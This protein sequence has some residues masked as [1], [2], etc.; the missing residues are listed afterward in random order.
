M[1]LNRRNLI[2]AG[3]A[4]LGGLA[5]GAA[6]GYVL[7]RQP[8]PFITTTT[9]LARTIKE[10]V[11]VT[12][13]S[14]KQTI[15][16]GEVPALAIAPLYVALEKD[17]FSKQG[18]EPRLTPIPAGSGPSIEAIV[19][20]SV[21][22]SS[23]DF[24][25]VMKLADNRGIY[26]KT[27]HNLYVVGNYRGRK[28]PTDTAPSLIV[29]K[30]VNKISDLKGKKI[31]VNALQALPHMVVNIVLQKAGLNPATDVNFVEIPFVNMLQPLATGEVDAALMIEPFATFAIARGI[32]KPLI[33]PPALPFQSIYP[34]ALGDP[35]FVAAYFTT[36][37]TLARKKSIMAAFARTIAEGVRHLYGDLEESTAILAKRFNLDKAVI[38][39]SLRGAIFAPDP[40]G[41][42]DHEFLRPQMENLIKAGYLTK[43]IELS[44]LSTSFTS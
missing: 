8:S 14:E 1:T 35:V 24:A 40:N 41:F 9:T 21:D 11:T 36:E 18:L 32:G 19:S 13:A 37:S 39:A 4:A 44:N 17:L 12:P 30:D 34:V 28:T 5:V 33:D 42:K 15:T 20:G 7:G 10:T 29:R 3:V 27:V 31:A 38:E 22:V 2:A 16:I 26:L 6:G 43:Q 25:S 23:V